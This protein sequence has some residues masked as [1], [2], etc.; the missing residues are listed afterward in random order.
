MGSKSNK[1]PRNGQCKS[2]NNGDANKNDNT[3]MNPRLASGVP[4][5][6]QHLVLWGMGTYG[7]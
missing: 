6:M 2:N 1:N 7:S 5:T 4:T 3:P